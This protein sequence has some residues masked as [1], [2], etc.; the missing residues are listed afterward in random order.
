[1]SL[2]EPEH[3]MLYTNLSFDDLPEEVKPMVVGNDRVVSHPASAEWLATIT[4]CCHCGGPLPEGCRYLCEGC[5][6]RP[7]WRWR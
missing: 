7:G 4:T 3:L 2:L 5:R 6:V 1:V